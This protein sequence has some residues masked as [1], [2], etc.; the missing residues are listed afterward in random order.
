MKKHRE[1][2]I[3]YSRCKNSLA[4]RGGLRQNRPSG[5]RAGGVLQ[6][7]YRLYGYSDAGYL[8]TVMGFETTAEARRWFVEKMT[9]AAS[10]VTNKKEEK[11][12]SVASENYY[13]KLQ[14]WKRLLPY[15]T[16][17]LLIQISL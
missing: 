14:R 1:A 8:P 13:S 2:V 11:V 7:G 3:V 16:N 9:Q 12:G 15:R 17:K 5:N 4:L 6:V 10:N